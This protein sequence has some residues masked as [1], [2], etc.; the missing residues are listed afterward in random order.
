VKITISGASGLIGRR[1]L[2]TL[3]GAGHSLQVLS[4]HAGMNM[5]PNVKVFAWD[6]LKGEPPAESLRDA[7]AVV[8]LAGEPVAQRWSEDVKRRIRDSR[9]TGTRS[10]VQAMTRAEKRPGTFVCAS[11]VGYYGSRGDDVLNESSPPGADY[12]ADVCREWEREAM[13]AEVAGIRVVC[14]R[15]GVVLDPRGGAL[16]SMLPPFRMGVGGKIGS[17]RQWMPWIHGQDLSEL[18]RFAVENPVKGAMNGA[19]P[20]PVR[21]ADF[22]RVLGAALHRPA[23]LPMPEFALR[24]IFG[25]MAGVLTASQRALPEA[26]EN[27]GFQFRFPELNGA[28]ADLLK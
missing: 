27:A 2:K 10:L 21:N 25:E 9:V 16:A 5:P 26:A 8:H 17:G 14:V 22:A 23:I 7:D 6:P 11:A 12:L 13:A 24:M 28:L 20:N 3:G 15:T 19:A 18:F 1:L 4:R